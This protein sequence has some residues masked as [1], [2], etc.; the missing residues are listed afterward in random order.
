MP[1]TLLG[2]QLFN[3]QDLIVDSPLLLL[4]IS[5]QISYKNFMLDKNN[6]ELISLSYDLLVGKVRILQGEV[7]C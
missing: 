2:V 6:F 3:S 1:V 4:N 5:L 7:T